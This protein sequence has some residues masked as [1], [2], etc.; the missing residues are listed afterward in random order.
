MI[1]NDYPDLL[2]IIDIKNAALI[3]MRYK[4]HK[5]K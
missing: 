3:K 1:Y 2:Q 4:N 5:D